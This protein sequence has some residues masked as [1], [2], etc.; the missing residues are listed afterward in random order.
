MVN[1]NIQAKRAPAD[2]KMYHIGIS[3]DDI[4]GARIAI[5]PGDPKRAPYLAA[6]LDENFISLGSNREYTSCLARVAGQPILVISTG[7]G[8]PSMAIGLEELAMIGLDKFIRVGTTGAIQESVNI[9]DIILTTASVRLDGT[10]RHYAQEVYPA[11]ADFRLTMALLQSAEALQAPVQVGITA[12]SDS[13]WPGQERYDSFTGFVRRKFQG[14]MDM[15]RKLNV[16]N[17][18]MESS[19]LLTISSVFGTQAACLSAVIAKRTQSEQ[20]DKSHYD[21][22]MCKIMAIVRK[23]IEEGRI[24]G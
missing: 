16:L 2:Q 7:M 13:F 11:V 8:G 21:D 12:S 4:Q 9:G 15:W 23:T 5:L 3:A 1:T 19:T 6:M 24:G 10:S 17:F 20:V 18:E 22:S 14:S